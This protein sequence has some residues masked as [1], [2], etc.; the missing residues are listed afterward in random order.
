MYLAV[1]RIRAPGCVEISVVDPDPDRIRI[2]G[3]PRIRIRIQEGKN[4]QQT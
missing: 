1:F 4:D 3:G 2:Q